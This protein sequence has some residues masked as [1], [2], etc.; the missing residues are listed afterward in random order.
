M[1]LRFYSSEMLLRFAM[2]PMVRRSASMMSD[3][4]GL[5][6]VGKRNCM[7]IVVMSYISLISI[8]SDADVETAN[9]NNIG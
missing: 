8:S 4:L 1:L 3:R 9:E 7:V 2:P 6:H 5:S